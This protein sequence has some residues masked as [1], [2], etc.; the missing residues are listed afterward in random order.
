MKLYIKSAEEENKPL[1]GYVGIWWIFG[2]NNIY[3]IRCSLDDGSNI[4]G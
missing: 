3:S 1:T 2:N 4:N